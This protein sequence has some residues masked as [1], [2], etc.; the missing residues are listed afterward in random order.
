MWLEKLYES[1]KTFILMEI[2]KL[3]FFWRVETKILA[4]NRSCARTTYKKLTVECAHTSYSFYLSKLIISLSIQK[5]KI[6]FLFG[7]SFNIYFSIKST[8]SEI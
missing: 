4:R 2:L 8:K 5:F 7:K 1:D 6:G 3:Y